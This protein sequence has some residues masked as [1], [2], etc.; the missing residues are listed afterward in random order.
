MKKSVLLA[1][2]ML[3][4]S[5][6][7]GGRP[8]AG[9]VDTIFF[10]YFSRDTVKI[11]AD[12]IWLKLEKYHHSG[13]EDPKEL[14]GLC[15]IVENLDPQN[16]YAWIIDAYLLSKRLGRSEEALRILDSGIDAN[17]SHPDRDKLFAEAAVI[18]LF[19]CHDLEKARVYLKQA[20]G[21]YRE[22]LEAGSFYMPENY[23][24]MLN[25]VAC[26]TNDVSGREEV[27]AML[28]QYGIADLPDPETIRSNYEKQGSIS[29]LHLKRV[30]DDDF[31]PICGHTHGA[32]SSGSS[33]QPLNSDE[34]EHESHADGHEA[35]ILPF[36]E[37]GINAGM[38]W[39]S[40]L[41]LVLALAFAVL[42]YGRTLKL[43]GFQK[44]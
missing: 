20:L 30:S 8:N 13:V 25:I 34:H 12:A 35:L 11:L 27:K 29:D 28:R 33:E 32:D 4:I 19:D 39:E 37:H 5:G 44:H 40:A 41:L 14:I 31:C 42:G 22:R 36:Q 15:R 21:S 18:L 23:L 17:P 3:F 7:V 38:A 9:P 1:L 2:A 6:V 10:S 24:R 43:P 16:I 26:L